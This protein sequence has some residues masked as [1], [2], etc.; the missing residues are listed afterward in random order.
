MSES[1]I[2]FECF[3]GCVE[4]RAGGGAGA[5]AALERARA[6]LLDAHRRLSRFDPGSEL[7]RLNRDQRCE[8]PASPLLRQLAVAIAEAGERSGGLVDGTLLRE[9]ER[10]GYA[11]S[12]PQGRRPTPPPAV[13]PSGPAGPRDRADWAALRVDQRAGTVIRPPG[14]QIDGGGLAKGMLADL[15]GA[16]L[17][18]FGSFAVDCCGDLRLGGRAGAER[19]V[20]VDDP[21]G[22]PPVGELR[23]RAGGVATSGISRRS[24]R[25]AGGRPGH[26]IIDPRSG[27]PA[28]TG[29]LQATAVAPTALLAE[30]YA[31]AALLAGPEEA[32]AWLPFGGVLVL[33]GGTVETVPASTE[34]PQPVP[35]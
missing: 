16:D 4:V 13:A 27:E 7:S 22:G 21:G 17:A 35:A 28:F 20:M 2:E 19:R 25:R 6:R 23:L 11:D 24:W 14:V 12:L 31:K 15:L 26:Q 10:A 29:V 9:I 1:R 33:A 18:G 30:V 3:G 8:V 34:L 5:P 32:P